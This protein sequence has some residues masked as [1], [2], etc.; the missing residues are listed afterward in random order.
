MAK[1]V[2]GIDGSE[3]EKPAEMGLYVRDWKVYLVRPSKSD[4][5][6]RYAVYCGSL[7]VKNQS[8]NSAAYRSVDREY[9]PGLVWNLKESERMT[10]EQAK[11]FGDLYGFCAWC[12][13]S[14]SAPESI[15]RGMG[16]HCYR[17]LRGWLKPA[18][19]T[20]N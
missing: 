17:M 3:A 7:D 10:P 18:T 6:H 5:T 9:I 12:G 2:F 4:P 13:Y 8:Y 14:L 11:I 20:T 1:F 19:S 15:L 16:P